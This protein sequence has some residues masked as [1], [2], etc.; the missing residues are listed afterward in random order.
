MNIK[1]VSFTYSK[2]SRIEDGVIPTIIKFDEKNGVQRT[3]S[4]I[5]ILH[6]ENE[7]Y[8]SA[9]T[10]T[11]NAGTDTFYNTYPM[12]NMTTLIALLKS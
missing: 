7:K 8:K 5:R 11:N 4:N 10:H 6:G 9:V 1:T 3:E 12:L 2:L